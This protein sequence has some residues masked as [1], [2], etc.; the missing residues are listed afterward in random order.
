MQCPRMLKLA[1]NEHIPL[2]FIFEGFASNVFSSFKQVANSIMETLTSLDGLTDN[3][4]ET[5]T[6]QQ[7]FF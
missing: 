3:Y 7:G 6:K 4:M 5:L 1:Q 2:A